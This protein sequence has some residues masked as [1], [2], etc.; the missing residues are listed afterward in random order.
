MIDPRDIR[1]DL[2]C[3]PTGQTLRVRHTPTGVEVVG[4]TVA[5]GSSDDNPA[6]LERERDNLLHDLEARVAALGR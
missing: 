2:L 3:G 5:S 6:G 4:A 1:V